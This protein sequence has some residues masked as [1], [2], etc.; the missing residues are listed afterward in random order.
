MIRL[1]VKLLTALMATM[2]GTSLMV[3]LECLVTLIMTSNSPNVHCASSP[4][5]VRLSETV[6]LFPRCRLSA[7]T[8]PAVLRDEEENANDSRER[9]SS[10]LY[11]GCEAN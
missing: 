9:H 6:S 1:K 8:Q 2:G 7:Y 5:G 11:M 4:A 3:H 10:V